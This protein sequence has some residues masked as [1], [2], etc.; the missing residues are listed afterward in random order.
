[1]AEAEPMVWIVDAHG[2]VSSSLAIA[3]R[4]SGFERVETEDPDVLDRDDARSV[5]FAPSDIVLVGL[6]YGD[7]RTTLPLIRPLVGRGCRVV[8]MTSDQALPLA[9]ECL[10]CGAEAVLNK[11]M[12]FERLVAALRRL[13]AGECAM[14]ED[15]RIALLETV[16]RQG[17]ADR[18]LRRPFE[19]LTEREADVLAA[20][21]AGSSP[22]QIAHR[23]GIAVST[24]RG[25]IQ[26][27]LT[28]L[29]VSS[30]RE[31]LAMARH[32]GWLPRSS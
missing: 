26:R 27:V 16:E 18:A 3:L 20:L 13:I 2:L 5:D 15:E 8:V 1:M 28:K 10:A 30:Q 25:H 23:N 7:G 21:V 9:G 4:H 22:K 19:A 6:L 29:G 31:A 12:S 32:A 14:T 11:D 24:V 17:A